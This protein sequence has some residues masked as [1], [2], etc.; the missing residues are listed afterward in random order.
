LEQAHLIQDIQLIIW[1]EVPMQKKEVV[2]A[3]DKCLQD[4]TRGNS[5]FSGIPVVLRDNWAQ[6]FPVVL[7]GSRGAIVYACLQQSYI[8][9][10]LQKV[11]L[12]QKMRATD[13]GSKPY[14]AWLRWMSL[15]PVLFGTLELPQ[16]F[17]SVHQPDELLF[18]IFPRDQLIHADNIYLW[19][20]H[21]LLIC[22]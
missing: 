7:G 21:G 6:I 2:E 9:L 1:D 22:L 18:F 15:S 14:I 11:F 10:K 12:Q 3:V 17:T 13:P 16:F 19:F 8:W 5:L 4:I 20:A